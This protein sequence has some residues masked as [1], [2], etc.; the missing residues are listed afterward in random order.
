MTRVYL[1][2][3]GRAAAGWDTDP[4]PGL[5]A[6]GVGIEEGRGLGLELLERDVGHVAF[7]RISDLR[8]GGHGTWRQDRW[9]SPV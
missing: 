3:H 9:A 4:D 1:V 8:G 5:D 6:L 7:P 2:R